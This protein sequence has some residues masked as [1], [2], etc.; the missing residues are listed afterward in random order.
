M[1]D[2]QD[3]TGTGGADS[4]ATAAR[5]DERHEGASFEPVPRDAAATTR[6]YPPEAD[7]EPDVA[8]PEAVVPGEQTDP[9]RRVEVFPED[10]QD[11]GQDADGG[12]TP[13]EHV[14][15]GSTEPPD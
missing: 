13:S 7:P 4:T 10:E 9:D 11:A 2:S 14:T 12:S 5:N 8:V 1:S 3:S 15:P 6:P